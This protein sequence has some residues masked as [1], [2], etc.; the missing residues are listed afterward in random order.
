MMEGT[1]KTTRTGKEEL[2]FQNESSVFI[3]RLMIG[4][5]IGCWEYWGIFSRV[6]EESLLSP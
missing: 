2:N 5:T 1:V 3:T 4:A 6:D